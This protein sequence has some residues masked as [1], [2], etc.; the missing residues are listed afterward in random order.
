MKTY[1]LTFQLARVIESVQVLPFKYF[2]WLVFINE[3]DFIKD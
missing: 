3:H 2:L 1:L